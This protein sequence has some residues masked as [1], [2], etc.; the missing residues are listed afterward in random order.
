VLVSSLITDG[1]SRQ[2]LEGLLGS[3]ETVLISEPILDEFLRVTSEERLS[4]YIHDDDITH[5]LMV[6]F[7]QTFLVRIRSRFKA[8]KSPDDNI[9]RTAKDGRA[10]IIVSGD[11]HLLNLKEFKGIRIVSV[12]E[13]LEDLRRLKSHPQS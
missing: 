11:A 9:L 12:S 1:K 2:L 7:A 13:M 5:F 10:D 3:E 8:L 4:K 6:L